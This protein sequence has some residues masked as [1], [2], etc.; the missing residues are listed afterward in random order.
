[1][2]KALAERSPATSGS[3][4]DRRRPPSP[5]S[6]SPLAADPASLSPER[7]LQLQRLAGNATVTA[8]VET[9]Q[10]ALA[11]DLVAQ[12]LPPLASDPVMDL[13]D[14]IT[15][16]ASPL[17]GTP[18]ARGIWDLIRWQFTNRQAGSAAASKQVGPVPRFKNVLY[19]KSVADRINK[20]KKA[21]KAKALELIFG[22]L[23]DVA[24]VRAKQAGGAEGFLSPGE[25]YKLVQASSLARFIK[26]EAA[27]RGIRT[28]LLGAFGALQV[29]TVAALTNAGAYYK[30][31]VKVDNFMGKKL[32]WT[33]YVHPDL[34]TAIANAEARLDAIREEKTAQTN[35]RAASWWYANVANSVSNFGDGVSIRA[36]ANNALEL[37]L[38]SYGWAI[39]VNASFNPNVPG[40]PRDLVSEMTGVDV[41]SSSTGQ[42]KGNFAR[43]KSGAE[44]RKE[45]ERLRQASE[46]FAG[47]FQSQE[48]LQAA[49]LKL[50]N[51]RLHAAWD[52][53]QMKVIYP[54][55]QAA[56][57][58][59]KGLKKQSDREAAQ[60]S[61]RDTLT[62]QL[63]L[64]QDTVGPPVAL[65][66]GGFQRLNLANTL[67]QLER[68]Y[69]RVW[70]KYN[71]KTKTMERVAPQ[72]RVTDV[73]SIA[74]HG[75]M[76]LNADLVAAL[77]GSEG[78]K[79]NWLGAVDE[80]NTKDFMHFELASRP[81]LY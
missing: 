28:G 23:G 5:A 50:I 64:L 72:A 74:A 27:Y 52:N 16:A 25:E 26:S 30:S 24:D 32:G 14:E 43:G 40:F 15:E 11:P 75:F 21:Q 44:V 49:M 81:P 53:D 39:D 4:A 59:G 20:L 9:A 1:M 79:L 35:A 62:D 8:L 51:G 3:V 6:R 63:R 47:A 69:R 73:A 61:A 55:V 13:A 54:L 17:A 67:L 45:A 60:A 46:Q 78:G 42:S 22:A 19:S 10:R 56:I 7:M 65:R 34:S 77:A 58:A 29:G 37:S 70:S 68:L 66:A 38:H 18:G 2:R 36:N 76:N 31:M 57:D 12:E 33:C 80:S 48:A 41:F 71:K